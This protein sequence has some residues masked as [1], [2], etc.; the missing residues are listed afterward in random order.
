V[1]LLGGDKTGD[2]RFYERLMPQVEKIWA[3][4]LEELAEESRK[5]GSK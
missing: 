4:Y 2:E 1:L 3:E 5:G